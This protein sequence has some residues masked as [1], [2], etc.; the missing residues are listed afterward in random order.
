MIKKSDK[1]YIAG[2]NGMVGSAC[3]R[4]LETEGYTNLIGKTSKELDLRNQKDV[5]EF[6]QTEKPF[7]IVDAA[8]KVGGILANDT[9][10]YE[11]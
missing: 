3:W 6:I 2:H 9:Y 10:P 8:A 4:V 1:I 5:E 7:A 11:F